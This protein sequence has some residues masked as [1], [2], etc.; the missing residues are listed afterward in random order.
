LILVEIAIASTGAAAISNFNLE[1]VE[2][3]YPR[4]HLRGVMRGALHSVMP[5]FPSPQG[6]V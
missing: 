1:R 5:A 2:R 3:H 6:S 4:G